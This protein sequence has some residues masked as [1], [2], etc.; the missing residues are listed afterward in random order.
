MFMYLKFLIE[1]TPTRVKR[2][3]SRMTVLSLYISI[4]MYTTHGGL[5]RLYITTVR[6]LI[7]AYRKKK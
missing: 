5:S 1:E 6:E 3:K 2:V 7:S 4:Y